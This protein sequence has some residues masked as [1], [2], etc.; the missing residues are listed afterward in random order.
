MQI[1]TPDQLADIEVPP[2]GL[3]L[4]WPQIDVD[5]SIASLLAGTFGPAKF[6][7]A[8]R[9]NGSSRSAA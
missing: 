5:V 6:M 9:R 2:T 8:Q 4:R 1:A 3:S 7:E